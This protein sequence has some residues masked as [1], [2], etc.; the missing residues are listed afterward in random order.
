MSAKDCPISSVQ[1]YNDRA[2]VTRQINAAQLSKGGEIK[3][4]IT[5]LVDELDSASVRIKGNT[6]VQIL[7]VTQDRVVVDQT[8]N[9]NEL[10]RLR[11]S[12]K[13]LRLRIDQTVEQRSR[14]DK[15]REL[16][17]TFAE[18]S[19]QRVEKVAGRSLDE[20]K[21][22]IAWYTAQMDEAAAQRIVLD[23]QIDALNKE[24]EAIEA[25]IRKVGAVEGGNRNDFERTLTVSVDCK[26]FVPS[27]EF[28]D[29][30][31]PLV[32]T[33]AV[34]N[35]SWSPSYDVRINTEKNTM[36][37]V[38][39][40]EVKQATGE[41]WTNV[42]MLLSTANPSI[43]SV[44]T[45]LTDSIVR[46][47]RIHYNY[48]NIRKEGNMMSKSKKSSSSQSQFMQQAPMMSALA[49]PPAP[50]A[51]MFGAL[52]G[53]GAMEEGNGDEELRCDVMEDASFAAT[54]DIKGGANA[55]TTAFVIPRKSTIESDNMSH[56]VII[57]EIR[58]EP[59]I[60]HYAA[61]S[62]TDVNVYLQAKTKNTSAY[63][64]LHSKKVSVFLDG[65]FISTASINQT[66]PGSNF[67]LYLGVD[68]SIKCSFRAINE[69]ETKA[70]GL[71]S[72]TRAKNFG[73]MTVL[74][75][76]RARQVKVLLADS[77]PKSHTEKI[78]VEL[79]DP[80][81]S[82]VKT[83]KTTFSRNS[84][85]ASL[86]EASLSAASG[87]YKDEVGNTLI[88]VCTLEPA[89]KKVVDFKYQVSYPDNMQIEVAKE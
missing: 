17:Q 60:V 38:Y 87:V 32:L 41:D 66:S 55:L 84:G 72:S 88:W 57:A 53:G 63:A 34:Y 35:A 28:P 37:L 75:N 11:E 40:A 4:K 83:I 65:A 49:A 81:P 36:Q 89:E 58:F 23:R 5:Q 44:P 50:G 22:I 86:D 30:Q 42:D 10:S 47:K 2:E 12:K 46:E 77:L 21:E 16:T 70:W 19:F 59:Q 68:A 78:V 29:G 61:P 76:S 85:M 51:R 15:S 7:E 27:D 62:T 67:Y 1:V 25:N 64:L 73:F 54:A 33:Y 80:K 18:G 52:G 39:F 13:A 82:A 31:P 20:A 3:L 56:K 71:V 45:A 43:G 9:V 24:M 14:L 6:F 48:E 26:E 69:N 74:T 79:L 8:Q